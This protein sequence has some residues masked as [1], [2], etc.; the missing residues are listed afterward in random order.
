LSVC[1]ARSTATGF[2]NLRTMARSSRST[3]H[4]EN[5]PAAEINSWV[6]ASR[7]T[8]IPSHLGSNETCVAKFRVMPLRRSPLS[9]EPTM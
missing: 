5:T 1:A 4:S 7:S 6:S 8:L 9:V 3:R 2:V